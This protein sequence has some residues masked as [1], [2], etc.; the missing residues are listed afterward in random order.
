MAA[1]VHD[2]FMLFGDSITQGAWEPGR[3]G[4][5]QQL[6]HV[7]ARKLD[8]LNRGYSGYNTEWG[9]PVFKQ[10]IA[11]RTDQHAP[12]IR[13]LTIWFGAND[14]CIKPSPQH[15]PLDKFA[16]NLKEMIQLIKSPESDYYSPET[17]IILIT[18]PPVNTYQRRAD[19][20]AR[21]PPLKLDRLFDV[22]REYAE[23]VKRVG[24][25][26]GVATVDIWSE[27]WEAAGEDEAS[28]SQFF[29]DGLHLNASGY[30]ILYKALIKTIGDVYPEVHPDNLGFVFP[31][32]ADIDWNGDTVKSLE[33]R[34]T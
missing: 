3:N 23:A 12:K 1:Y 17:R 21:N 25:E 29:P 31:P 24:R 19:L 20:E 9:L 8:V 28:L 30:E 13:V 34:R 2:V 6:S 4:F 18:P 26:T 11:K 16:S 27:I 15:V 22:T 14:A 33:A 10:I 5:G 32:W 7:Y